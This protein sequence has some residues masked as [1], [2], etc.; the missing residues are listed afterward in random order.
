V[1]AIH[2]QTHYDALEVSAG[3]SPEQIERAYQLASEA[4][5]T[6]SLAL[7]S[8]FEDGDAEQIR[9]R[10]EEA[11]RVLADSDQRREY[12]RELAAAGEPEERS[13]ASEEDGEFEQDVAFAGHESTSAV[14]LSEEIEDESGE[15]N[16]PKLR[17][18][19]MRRGVELEK[20]AEI[21][22][23]STA[24]LRHL[25][26]ERFEDLPANV[27]VRGFVMAYAKTIGLD[28]E[29]VVGSYLARVEQARAAHSRSRFLGRR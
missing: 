13:V 1:K 17:R 24:N 18:A 14:D 23:I 5:R 8:V 12:D 21:T 3:A 28:A 9:A 27:Y 19:R 15:F 20:I 2:Q 29:A 4:Y 16:G 26:E 7:Y 22:K 11:Y 25:E 10:I 6:D